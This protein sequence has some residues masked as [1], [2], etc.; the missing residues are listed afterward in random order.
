MRYLKKYK[1][2]SEAV[3]NTGRGK[4]IDFMLINGEKYLLSKKDFSEEEINNI[5]DIFQDIVDEFSLTK[6]KDNYNYDYNEYVMNC[7][8]HHSEIPIYINKDGIE[9]S[10]LDNLKTYIIDFEKRLTIEGYHVRHDIFYYIDTGHCTIR[11]EIFKI[12]QTH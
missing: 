3:K 4:R 12:E 10:E 8:T 9:R 5:K 1:S 11:I 6:S 2:I 7:R